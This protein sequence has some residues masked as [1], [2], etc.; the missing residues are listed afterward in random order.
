MIHM[1]YFLHSGV[2]NP[3][4]VS[5]D[6]DLTVDN[7]LNYGNKISILGGDFLLATASTELAKLNNIKVLYCHSF[8]NSANFL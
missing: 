4:D 6:E 3:R 5:S 7:A 8:L 2:V 1:G